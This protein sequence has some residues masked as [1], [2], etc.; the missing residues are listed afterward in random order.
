MCWQVLVP[1]A[2]SA[3]GAAAN[4]K[5]ETDATERSDKIATDA[6]LRQA[7]NNREADTKVSQAVQKIA[8]SNPQAAVNDRRTQYLDALRRAQ[9]ETDSAMPATPGASARF[10]EDVNAA[11]M[12]ATA[13]GA[14]EAD[15]L[16]NLE[17]P[18]IQRQNE[19]NV[20]AQAGSD[21]GLIAGR[22]RSDDYLTRLRLARVRPNA[23]LKAFGSL[24]SG[25]GG[26]AASNGGTAPTTVWD[27][28]T[29]ASGLTAQQRRNKWLG[30]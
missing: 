11:G 18:G 28:G 19:A 15:T 26:A 10:A 9:P 14:D 16:A 20:T 23:S 8:A 25:A 4:R 12:S 29:A 30:A 24:L 7:A 1:L 5:A 13:R 2:A 17:A 22:S 27:D 21:L 6:I 3:A